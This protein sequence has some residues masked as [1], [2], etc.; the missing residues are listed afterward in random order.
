MKSTLCATLS[1]AKLTALEAFSIQKREI[2]TVEYGF[3]IL[4]LTE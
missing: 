1:Y 3:Y 4:G 2:P